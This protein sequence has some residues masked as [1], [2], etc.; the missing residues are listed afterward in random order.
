MPSE[1]SVAALML[2]R[3][4]SG[5]RERGN[6]LVLLE[7]KERGRKGKEAGRKL[8]YSGVGPGG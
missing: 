1:E 3:Q 7:R 5:S 8:N 2:G 6:G 4:E